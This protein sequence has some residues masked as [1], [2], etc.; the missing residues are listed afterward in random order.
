MLKVASEVLIPGLIIFCNAFAFAGDD[1]CGKIR[2][3]SA[4][5]GMADETAELLY[6][7]R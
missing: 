2:Q 4:D 6:D 1:K 7:I 3:Q 5:K